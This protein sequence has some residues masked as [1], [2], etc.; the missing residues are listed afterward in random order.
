VA[1]SHELKEELQDKSFSILIDETTD[2]SVSKLLA[3]LVRHWDTR[4]QKVVDDLLGLVEVVSASGE[5]L[6]VAVEGKHFKNL[7][8]VKPYSHTSVHLH[9]FSSVHL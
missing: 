1:F 2:T 5:D 3:V 9:I 4:L 8:E 7:L 6:F